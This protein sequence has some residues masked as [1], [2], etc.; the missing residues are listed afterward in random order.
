M[1]M[2]Y[3]NQC[4]NERCLPRRHNPM[5]A[6]SVFESISRFHDELTSIRQDIHA[7]PELGFQEQRTSAIVANALTALGYQVHRNV[8]KTGVVG[9]LEEIGRASGRERVERSGR[10]VTSA[11][12]PA[13]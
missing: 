12:R 3:F 10:R 1:V 13:G 7:H 2:F 5:Y 6:K 11:A 4:R 9:G 8:G